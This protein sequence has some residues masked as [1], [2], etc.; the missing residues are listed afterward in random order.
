MNIKMIATDLDN[1]LLLPDCTL[2]ARSVETL[3]RCR[4][5]GIKIAFATA[6]SECDCKLYTDVICPDAIISNRGAI[7]TAGGKTIQRNIIDMA[8]TNKLLAQFLSHPRVGHAY[9]FTDRGYYTNL[10][11]ELHNTAWGEYNRELFTDYAY[12]L[13]CDCYKISAEIF[14]HEAAQEIAAAFPELNMVKFTGDSYYCFSHRRVNKLE[15]VKVLA[16][17][18]KINL[19]EIA[20]FGD[21]YSDIEML[22]G[23]VGVAVE[24]AIPEAKAAAVHRCES[25]END[26]VANWIDQNIIAFSK[27]TNYNL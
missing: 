23:C 24:N 22:Q 10:P 19:N 18:L 17:A 26:G 13:D 14:C 25:N 5:M 4:N 15:G 21:D 7:I 8:T 3:N 1:T 2:S 27:S 16:S 9:V 11:E 6:R 20:A 12:G